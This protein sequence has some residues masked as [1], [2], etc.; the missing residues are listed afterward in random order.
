MLVQRKGVLKKSSNKISFND[1]ESLETPKDNLYK[2]YYEES[3]YRFYVGLAFILLSLASGFQWVTF[4]SCFTNFSISYNLPKWKVN[5]FSLI[6]MIVYPIVCIP[7]GY[8]MDYYSIRAGIVLASSLTVCGAIFKLFVNQS[9]EICFFGQ[10]ITALGQPLI[11]DSVGK[12]AA[13]WFN[14]NSRTLVTTIFCV[15]NTL[16]VLIG[17]VFFNCII[18]STIDPIINPEAYKHDFF[19]NIFCQFLLNVILCFPSFFITSDSPTYPTSPSQAKIKKYPLFVALKL[20]LMNERFICLVVSAFF[21]IGYFNVFG[22]ICYNVFTM[23]QVTEAQSS[24]I[25]GVANFCGILSAL[26]ISIWVDKTKKFKLILLFLSSGG[27]I[28]QTLFTVLLEL[29]LIYSNFSPNAICMTM[30]SLVSMMV[31]PFYTIGMNYACEITYPVGECI[32]G[33]LIMSISQ[34]AG[35]GG[36]FFCESLIEKYPEKKYLVNL[37]MILFFVFAWIACLF[38]DD[39]LERNDVE[40]I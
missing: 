25:Y 12:I 6:Y 16:G 4:S 10:T 23:Y 35:I 3:P 14:N 19:L 27:I 24:V 29:S 34:L 17:Y 5:M 21:V 20:L 9:L 32:N 31:T 37:V 18:D 28:L 30:Y 7:Q 8:F 26:I 38:L 39:S 33:G 15:S 22:T 40:T 2:E 36:T 11:L 1:N 13:R